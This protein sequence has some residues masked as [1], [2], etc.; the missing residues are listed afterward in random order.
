MATHAALA[1]S[2]EGDEL[3]EDS[4]GDELIQRLYDPQ[5]AASLGVILDHADL[6]AT[7]IQGLDGMLRRADVISD[8]SGFSTRPRPSC[9]RR[10]SCSRS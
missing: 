9:T 8:T 4:P 5:V 7:V 10:G 3:I 1:V 2:S 6:L